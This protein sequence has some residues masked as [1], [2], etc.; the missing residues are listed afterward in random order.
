MVVSNRIVF[1]PDVPF[2]SG[3]YAF[4]PRDLVAYNVTNGVL[5]PYFSGAT[6]GLPER[7]CIDATALRPGT[8]Q[9]LVSFDVTL[10]LP[11]LGIVQDEDIVAFQGAAPVA[12]IA[13]RT[14]GIP[15]GA[16]LDA[17]YHDGTNLFF[18]LD[19]SATIGG[20]TGT[21]NDVWQCRTNPL[22]VTLITGVGLD[23]GA[24][25]VALD[26][27]IDSDGDWLS[28]FEEITGR[29]DPATTLP[30]TPLGLTPNG[31]MSKP[32]EADSDHDG[33]T[34]G[35][36]ALAG[37]QPTNPASSLQLT[38]IVA[39]PTN[40]VITWSSVSGKRYALDA[41]DRLSLPFNPLA[42]G[43]VASGAT[44]SRTNATGTNT[45]FYRIRLDPVIPGQP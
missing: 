5:A 27:L 39:S 7:A 34:D 20:L 21:R 42:A 43:L 2:T 19:V 30:G 8:S 33:A 36:E 28:D 15:A 9:L 32:G 31:F 10:T 38:R 14:L 11:P 13:G 23:A 22:T 1:A 37:T 17:L 45:L 29:D 24:D 40:Q 26:A 16:D 18:S 25:L 4:T 3:A 44:M 12:L 41:A 6:A 35:E